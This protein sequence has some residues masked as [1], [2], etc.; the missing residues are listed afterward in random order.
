MYIKLVWDCL[1]VYQPPGAFRYKKNFFGGLGFIERALSKASSEP[2]WWPY[3]LV[4]PGQSFDVEVAQDGVE[5]L[6]G[7]GGPAYAL[8]R[9]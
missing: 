3:A 4:A 1:Y 7:W 2:L 6:R 9:R 5:E 8:E